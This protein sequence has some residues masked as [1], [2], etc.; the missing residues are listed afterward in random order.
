MKCARA[1]NPTRSGRYRA[2]QSA[3][4]IGRWRARRLAPAPKSLRKDLMPSGER[5]GY[6]PLG[7]V[8]SIFSMAAL[9]RPA[10]AGLHSGA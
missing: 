8:S 7:A 2:G 4:L 10:V 5:G 3:R 9:P 6:G 1:Y